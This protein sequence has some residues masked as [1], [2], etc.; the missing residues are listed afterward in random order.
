MSTP[1]PTMTNS[2][3]DRRLRVVIATDTFAPD[4]NGAARFAR[5]HAVRL[6]RRGHDV[7]VIAP[8]SSFGPTTV[9]REIFDGQS[10]HVH[11]LRSVRVPRHDW[12]RVPPPW[13]VRRRMRRILDAV[14]PDVVHLQS[15]IDIGRGAAYEAHEKGIPIVAT[16]HVM[17]DNL[18]S[19]R[20]VPARMVPVIARMAWRLASSV[21]ARADVVT[22]PTPIAAGYLERHTSIRK[23][24]PISCGVDLARFTPKHEKPTAASVLY[25]GRLD[26]EK[27]VATLVQAFA[28]VPRGLN[29]RLDIVGDGS[30]RSA[31]EKFTER[32]Q[33]TDRV[34]FHGHVSDRRLEELHHGATVFVMP[35][36]AELQ[37]IATL[38]ALASGTPVV[39]ADAM[40]LPHLV[41]DGAEGYLVPAH[42]APRFSHQ[43]A[44]ILGLSESGYRTMSAHAL[45][46]ASRHSSAAVTQQYEDI[47]EQARTRMRGVRMPLS[48]APQPDH[49][50]ATLSPVA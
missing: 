3:S 4:I 20:G 38:E 1:T 41:N 2:L 47:Y 49:E 26:P 33:L 10:I 23:V 6:S 44:K 39:L 29:A 11:R 25:V 31:L 16:N 15:F 36:S 30:E 37:S 9:Q 45:K 46:R 24:T 19:V 5:E 7:H 28:L 12:A 42:D 32:L 27:D 8:S 48:N 13:E 43:I 18:A 34:R 14:R 17:P 21:Y 22:S 50:L 35:S 40:A